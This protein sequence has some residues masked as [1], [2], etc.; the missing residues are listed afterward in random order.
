MHRCCTLWPYTLH[1]LIRLRNNKRTNKPNPTQP[2]PTQPNPTQPNPTQPNPTQPNPTQPN[3]TQPNPT[4][5]NPTQ[6]NPTTTLLRTATRTLV[7]ARENLLHERIRSHLVEMFFLLPRQRCLDSFHPRVLIVRT[8]RVAC[9]GIG[10]ER[11]QNVQTTT[12]DVYPKRAHFFCV[13]TFPWTLAS[14]P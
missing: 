10:V 2:N 4:Q 5:P 12:T 9:K 14:S 1:I 7:Y 11:A 3:P 13:C 6:P 8:D